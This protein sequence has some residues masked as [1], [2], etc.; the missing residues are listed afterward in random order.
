MKTLIFE[1]LDHYGEKNSAQIYKYLKKELFHGVTMTSLTS[2]LAIGEKETFYSNGTVKYK[3]D[4]RWVEV[5]IWGIREEKLTKEGKRRLKKRISS[6]K[7][8]Q[9][10]EV[11]A[12]N[13]A[14]N[15]DPERKARKRAY[16]KEYRQRPGIKMART[17]YERD[18]CNN[19]PEV[20]ER[21]RLSST[22]RRQR[23]DQRKRMSAWQ[24]EYNARPEVKEHSRA[25]RQDPEVK[26]RRRIY[27]QRPEVKE[28]RR[29]KRRE[30]YLRQKKLREEE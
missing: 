30:R 26:E 7:Y 5:K 20:K 23:P 2:V 12:R 25:Y 28:R 3:Q 14:R 21:Q 11:R 4:G 10:P 9:R 1:Y 27:L 17:Q 18:H 24:V 29:I 22:I 16:M 8:H 15:Q 19:N 13:Y 6:R